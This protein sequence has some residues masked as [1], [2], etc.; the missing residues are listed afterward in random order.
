MIEKYITAFKADSNLDLLSC[1]VGVFEHDNWSYEKEQSKIKK[2]YT[3]LAL[4]NSQETNL[5]CNLFGKGSFI[6]KK[7]V[8]KKI[9][10]YE[11]DNGPVPMVDYRFYIKAALSGVN[12]AVLPEALYLYRKNS[13]NSLF[14]TKENKRKNLFLAKKSMI[15]IF[16]NKLGE[17]I[18]S[19]FTHH[20][21]NLN[22]PEY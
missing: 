18:G 2:E 5:V 9:G 14:Y 11:T 3:S 22:K 15:E 19:S 12:I 7:E 1:F 17:E 21:W 13:P 8:F 20:I 6:V 10:G 4:G 16:K